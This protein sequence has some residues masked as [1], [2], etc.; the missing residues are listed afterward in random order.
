MSVDIAKKFLSD[1]QTQTRLQASLIAL[2]L[3]APTISVDNLLSFAARDG[4]TFTAAD[5]KQAAADSADAQGG[6]LGISLSDGTKINIL[7]E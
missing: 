5:W 7:C 2:S 4:Y 1:L 3:T 6:T